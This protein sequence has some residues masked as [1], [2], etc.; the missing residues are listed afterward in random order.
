VVI[1][2][3][4]PF[5]VYCSKKNLATLD[6][7]VA[8]GLLVIAV[9]VDQFGTIVCQHAMSQQYFEL[10]LPITQQKKVK[11]VPI[12]DSRGRCYDHNFLRFFPPNFGE[13]NWRFS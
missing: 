4:F 5:L 2:Y 9:S 6:A 10:P 8:T 13:K 1:W 12:V 11:V 7:M 3:L